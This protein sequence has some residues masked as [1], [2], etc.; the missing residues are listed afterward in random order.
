MKEN[1]VTFALDH[2]V[3]NWVTG[4]ATWAEHKSMLCLGQGDVAVANIHNMASNGQTDMLEEVLK[5]NC[6]RIDEKKDGMTPLMVASIAGHIDTVEMLLNF[7]ADVN[8]TEWWSE[9]SALVWA[10]ESGNTK[11]VALLIS[12][13]ACVNSSTLQGHSPLITACRTG[14]TTIAELLVTRGAQLMSRTKEGR[15]ALDYL[16]KEEDRKRLEELAG[17]YENANKFF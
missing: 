13:G 16:E 9:N 14:H 2:I 4:F 15:G 3:L 11:I 12:H 8:I 10:C 1:N 5:K 6:S 7:G 17:V